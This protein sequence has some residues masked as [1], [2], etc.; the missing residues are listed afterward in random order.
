MFIE[1]PI[2]G[3]NKYMFDTSFGD[4]DKGVDI[5]NLLGYYEENPS[6]YT[7][8]SYITLDFLENISDRVSAFGFGRWYQHYYHYFLFNNVSSD[9]VNLR[10]IFS[11]S[12]PKLKTLSGFSIRE[13]TKTVNFEGMFANTS[14]IEEITAFMISDIPNTSGV[15]GLFTSLKKLK[16]FQTS[17]LNLTS[18]TVDWYNLFDWET[19]LNNYETNSY[20]GG[21][22]YQNVGNSFIDSSLSINKTITKDNYVKLWNLINKYN[23]W[24]YLSAFFK[25]CTF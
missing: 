21:G 2:E 23:K 17:C 20:F 1:N 10:D 19:L 7:I 6:V 3:Y 13:D 14:N 5:I 12:F 25:N 16:K 15:E 24:R 8:L 9:T 11:N 18:T 4:S 22:G